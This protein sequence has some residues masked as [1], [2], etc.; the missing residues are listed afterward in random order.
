MYSQ[1]QYLDP[2]LLKTETKT[3]DS[4]IWKAQ[5]LHYI[6]QKY[7]NIWIAERAKDMFDQAE[8][9]KAFLANRI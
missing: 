4:S 6:R 1:N 7:E 9:S 8:T 5:N 3:K 2:I